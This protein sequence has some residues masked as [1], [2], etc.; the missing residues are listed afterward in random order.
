MQASWKPGA[1]GN[2]SSSSAWQWQTIQFGDDFVPVEND[3]VVTDK[4]AECLFCHEF[5]FSELAK[6]TAD[7]ADPW[8]DPVNPHTYVDEDK[9]DPHHG[10]KIVPDC[11]KCHKEHELPAPTS[12]VADAK[13]NYC[14]SC[15][16]EQTFEVC[17]DCH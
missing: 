10:D 17:S 4:S 15:H 11:L 7:W 14:Y 6:L 13:L 8:G 9:A 2:S 5:Q 12:K 1:A 16:H 3:E